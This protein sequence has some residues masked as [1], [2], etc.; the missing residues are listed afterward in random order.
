MDATTKERSQEDV[1]VV[2]SDVRLKSSW[3]RTHL[4]AEVED[5][6]GVEL[7]VDLSHF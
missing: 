5:E 3:E 1:A 6:D 7:V 4:R 2:R